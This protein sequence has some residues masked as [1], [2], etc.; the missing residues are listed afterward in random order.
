[1]S[2]I[3][4]VNSFFILDPCLHPQSSQ[5][6]YKNITKEIYAKK[7]SKTTNLIAFL[8]SEKENNNLNLIAGV[9]FTF[10]GTNKWLFIGEINSELISLELIS[11]SVCTFLL[12]LLFFRLQLLLN[13]D[14]VEF[15]RR[16]WY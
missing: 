4:W 12:L 3:C 13:Q 9:N 14:P 2:F 7:K 8:K 11:L 16:C 1:M 5:L 10:K 15:L 6:Q